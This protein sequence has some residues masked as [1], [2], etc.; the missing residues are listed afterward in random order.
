MC[1]VAATLTLSLRRA[2]G[3]FPGSLESSGDNRAICVF[4]RHRFP[5]DTRIFDSALF[6]GIYFKK[7]TGRVFC[8][9]MREVPGAGGVTVHCGAGRSHLSP[10]FGVPPLLGGA[11][12]GCCFPV[13]VIARA[14][15]WVKAHDGSQVSAG[16]ARSII[17]SVLNCHYYY[18]VGAGTRRS[19]NANV[20]K[21]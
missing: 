14:G 7:E 13:I 16:P 6:T 8:V 3:N 20:R 15:I 4:Q 12:F 5:G 1:G 17:P 2:G 9:I 11:M 10:E 19:S 21:E 18:K